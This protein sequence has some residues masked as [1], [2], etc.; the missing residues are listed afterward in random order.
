MYIWFWIITHFPCDLSFFTKT[1]CS[2]HGLSHHS[3]KCSFSKRFIPL[4]GL[5]NSDQKSKCI[6]HTF[7]SCAND[8][9]LRVYDG[10][11]LKTYLLMRWLGIDALVVVRPTVVVYLF[12]FFCSRIQFYVLLKPYLCFTSFYILIYMK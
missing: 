12:D 7:R 8:L 3:L 10:S 2:D 11:D 4:P 9:R 1:A 6:C 5:E